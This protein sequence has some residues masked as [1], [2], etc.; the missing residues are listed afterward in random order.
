MVE[1]EALEIGLAGNGDGRGLGVI[2]GV[3]G[4]MEAWW[5]IGH[6]DVRERE[7]ERDYVFEFCFIFLLIGKN[8]GEVMCS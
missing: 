8:M 5:S 6:N 4:L 7:R 2:E 1:G 3:R